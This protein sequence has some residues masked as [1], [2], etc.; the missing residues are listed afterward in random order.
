MYEK[1]TDVQKGTGTK[2]PAF[3]FDNKTDLFFR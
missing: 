2:V 1:E 3:F